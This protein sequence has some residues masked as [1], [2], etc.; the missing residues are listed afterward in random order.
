MA[1]K[2]RTLCLP[3]PVSQVIRTGRN[4]G[5]SR[6][7]DRKGEVGKMASQCWHGLDVIRRHLD[8]KGWMALMPAF[9]H[10]TGHFKNELG[11][12]LFVAKDEAGPLPRKAIVANGIITRS[13]GSLSFAPEA[14]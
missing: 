14:A 7:A 11:V 10:F 1:G 6:T 9:C 13:V 4:L 8:I 5:G 2:L 3:S 12:Q